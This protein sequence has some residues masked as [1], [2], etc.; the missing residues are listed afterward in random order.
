MREVPGLRADSAVFL[1]KLTERLAGEQI[2]IGLLDS[3]AGK[4]ETLDDGE[5]PAATIERI[6]SQELL[7]ARLLERAIRIVGGNSSIPS[8]SS[9][10]LRESSEC[11]QRIVQRP[12]GGFAASLEALLLAELRDGK[13]WEPLI[14]LAERAG[15]GLLAW[16]FRGALM[17]E[18]EHAVILQEWLDRCDER[19]AQGRWSA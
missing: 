19:A 17:E 15:L 5:F 18:R 8:L 7:H 9:T 6:R 10:R 4:T 12:G 14:T 2:N 13:G 1:D 16:E 3:L 11:L